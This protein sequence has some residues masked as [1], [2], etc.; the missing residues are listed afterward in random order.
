MVVLPNG[1]FIVEHPTKMDDLGVT[2]F[3][4]TSTYFKVMSPAD[5][6]HVIFFSWDAATNFSATNWGLS[7]IQ[8]NLRLLLVHS[9]LVH[10][11]NSLNFPRRFPAF[12]WANWWRFPGFLLLGV[13]MVP[14]QPPP[15]HPKSDARRDAGHVGTGSNDVSDWNGLWTH[16]LPRYKW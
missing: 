6:G 15:G 11:R 7:L 4:E 16:E 1:W 8:N 3:Q 12:F 2:P 9:W 5:G 13:A 10:S 14:I